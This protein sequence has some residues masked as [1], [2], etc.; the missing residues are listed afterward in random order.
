[1]KL[2]DSSEKM[3]KIDKSLADASRKKEDSSN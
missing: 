1:M 3:S 2:T